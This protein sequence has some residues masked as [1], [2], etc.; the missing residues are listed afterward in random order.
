MQKRRE[1]GKRAF[2]LLFQPCLYSAFIRIANNENQILIQNKSQ[3]DCV[4]GRG[5]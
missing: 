4:D 1:T 5:I 3:G 2:L